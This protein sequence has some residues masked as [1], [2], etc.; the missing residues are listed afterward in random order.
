MP[1]GTL[2]FENSLFVSSTYKKY[3]CIGESGAGW[4]GFL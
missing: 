4:A 1:I 3:R 2:F